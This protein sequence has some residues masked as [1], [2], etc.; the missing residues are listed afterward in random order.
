VKGQ[1]TAEEGFSVSSQTRVGREVSRDLM[2]M[3]EVVIK[4][5]RHVFF[6]LK[7]IRDRPANSCEGRPIVS[8]THALETMEG[9]A[10]ETRYESGLCMHGGR[11]IKTYERN[12]V[13]NTL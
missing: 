10:H 8:E 5:R 11:G 2:L 12:F 13:F 3:L 1:L 6:F 7:R 4:L 9:Y